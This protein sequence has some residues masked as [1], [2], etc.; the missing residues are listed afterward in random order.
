[1]RAVINNSRSEQDPIKTPTDSAREAAF[2]KST[3]GGTGAISREGVKALGTD[4][5]DGGGDEFGEWPLTAEE[6]LQLSQVHFPALPETP[7]KTAKRDVIATPGSKRTREEDTLPT[8][9]TRTTSKLEPC[10][11]DD[12]VFTSPTKRLKGGMWDSTEKSGLLS[13]SVTPNPGRIRNSTSEKTDPTTQETSTDYDITEQVIELLQGQ[14]ISNETALKLRDTLNKYAL[15]TSG[16]IK[17]R[18]IT[19]LALKTKDV[20]ISELQQRITSLETERAM[21]KAI[22]KN[23]KSDIAH[24]IASKQGRGRG[25]S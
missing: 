7:Q 17:G 8:P 1:M 6:E 5:D 25:H 22:I 24:S 4:G 11:K 14:T 19:R 10:L 9:Q 20:T 15:K 3:L 2:N 23:I 12:D 18:A 21:D 13:P 16:I